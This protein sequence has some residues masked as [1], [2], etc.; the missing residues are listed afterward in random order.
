MNAL[1]KF[2]ILICVIAN[3]D[4]L[5][6]SENLASIAI[7][8]AM[9]SMSFVTVVNILFALNDVLSK[10]SGGMNVMI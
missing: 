7:T 10:C 3:D 6:E 9:S 8:Q 4:V 5:V 1:I 2:M